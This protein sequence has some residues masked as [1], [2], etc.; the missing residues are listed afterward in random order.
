MGATYTVRVTSQ[1][2]HALAKEVES[3]LG[4]KPDRTIECSGAEASIATAIYVR[5]LVVMS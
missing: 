4:C 3:M 2:S 5:Q 1:D